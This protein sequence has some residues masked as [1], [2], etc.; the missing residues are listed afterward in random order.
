MKLRTLSSIACCKLNYV[1]KCPEQVFD[2][3]YFN[4][5]RCTTLK[6]IIKIIHS[7]L[8]V[9]VVCFTFQMLNSLLLY[10]W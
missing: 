1:G 7:N 10:A 8:A 9:F 6:S 2:K 4:K 5:V 3:K